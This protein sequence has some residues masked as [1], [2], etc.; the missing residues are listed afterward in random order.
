MKKILSKVLSVTLALTLVGTSINTLKVNAASKDNLLKVNYI[1]VGQGD[2]IFIQ[3]KDYEILIDAGENNMGQRVVNYIKPLVKGNLDLVIATHPD[4]DHI[5]G[6][7]VVLQNFKVNKII[8]SGWPSTTNT[9]KDYMT[10]VNKQVK[11]NGAVYSKKSNTTLTIDNDVKLDIFDQGSGFKTN[12]NNSV[13]S[14]LTYNNVGF[15]L[16]GDAEKEVEEVLLDRNLKAD[17]LK[18]G[19]HGSRTAS[20]LDFVKAVDPQ[21]VVIS[22]GLN[23]KFGHPHQ[24]ALST[25]DS[26]NLPYYRTDKLGSIVVDTDGTN[27]NVNGKYVGKGKTGSRDSEGPSDNPTIPTD[28][29][30]S[31]EPAKPTK[32]EIPP[33]VS[34]LHIQNIDAA[35]EIATIVNDSQAEVDLTGWYLVSTV[36]NQIY[37]FPKGYKLGAGESVQVVSGRNAAN[38]DRMLKW[39]GAYIW[40]NNNDPGELY[41][42]SGNLVSSFGR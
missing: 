27:I 39:S 15:M 4:S 11:N 17:V 19:H 9:Y 37:N 3:Y 20:S 28:P 38:G 21:F 2:S 14:K 35:N 41:D 30:D 12:N 16:Q 26:L 7:D 18:A 42:S 13:V 32:P 36:G 10:E 23:N 8:D 40:D 25:Y 31:T 6:M 1:D 22:C 34:G 24:E 29:T 5:G 33:T